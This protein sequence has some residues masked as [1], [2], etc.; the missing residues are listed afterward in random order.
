M[1]GLTSKDWKD[2][3]SCITAIRFGT[4]LFWLL[5]EESLLAKVAV[6]SDSFYFLRPGSFFFWTKKL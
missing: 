6:I 4:F 2:F 3:Q 5:P 1:Y